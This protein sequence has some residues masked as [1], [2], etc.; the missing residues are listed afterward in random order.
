MLQRSPAT[1]EAVCQP[2]HCSLDNIVVVMR[3]IIGV[4]FN[5]DEVLRRGGGRSGGHRRRRRTGNSLVVVN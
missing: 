1:L 3:G 4:F 5:S 2:W